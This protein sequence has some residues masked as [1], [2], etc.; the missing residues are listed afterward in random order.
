M[1]EPSI[2]G[3]VAQLDGIER[4]LDRLIEWQH[5]TNETPGMV[6]RMDRAEH[7]I[8]LLQESKQAANE[9]GWNVAMTIIG[10]A[11]TSVAAAALSMW[12][13]FRNQ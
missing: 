9:R 3:L 4:K 8:R 5:G 13:A 10:G 2:A 11:V 6:V 12:A 1:S 7:S